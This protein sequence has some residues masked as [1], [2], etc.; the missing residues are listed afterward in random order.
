MQY[1]TCSI[2]ELESTV[3]LMRYMKR[4]GLTIAALCRSDGV[5]T[6]VALPTPE[7]RAKIDSNQ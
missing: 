5:T 4:S 3:S 6:D 2:D 7:S 1:G